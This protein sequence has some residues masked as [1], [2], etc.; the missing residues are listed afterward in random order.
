MTVRW[1]LVAALALAGCG[2]LLGPPVACTTEPMPPTEWGEELP[3]Q[4]DIVCTANKD[5]DTYRVHIEHE[6]PS[7]PRS[8]HFGHHEVEAGEVDHHPHVRIGSVVT[9]EVEGYGKR[10]FTVR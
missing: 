9:V 10:R 3:D 8:E 4:R 5:L 6:D 2:K 7:G 1:A